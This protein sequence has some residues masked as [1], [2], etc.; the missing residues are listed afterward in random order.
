MLDFAVEIRGS[1]VV[2]ENLRQLAFVLGRAAR[3]DISR[4]AA[5]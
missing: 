3:R 5:I 1:W 4:T 2:E